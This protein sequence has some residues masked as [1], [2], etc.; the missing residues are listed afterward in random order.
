M[1]LFQHVNDYISTRKWWH[2]IIGKQTYLLTLVISSR[3]RKHQ[4]LIYH[5][6]GLY[7]TL[8]SGNIQSSRYFYKRKNQFVEQCVNIIKYQGWII[9]CLATFHITYWISHEPVT[10]QWRWWWVE[11]FSETTFMG[12]AYILECSSFQKDFNTG[13]TVVYVMHQMHTCI[14]LFSGAQ[15]K[16]VFKSIWYAKC[17]KTEKN[18]KCPNMLMLF[19]CVYW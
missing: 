4:L 13:Y 12:I 1:M 3:T 14:W 11:Q 9:S 17:R 2:L 10:S 15:S 7:V 18:T 5:L 16:I 6:P 19:S 8:P